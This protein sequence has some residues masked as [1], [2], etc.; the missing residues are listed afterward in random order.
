MELKQ[1][2]NSAPSVQGEYEPVFD[3]AD[4]FFNPANTMSLSRPIIGAIAANKLVNGET[5]VTA[6]VA[7]MALTDAEG[8]VARA[9]DKRSI[10]RTGQTN[11]YG[12][13]KIGKTLDP[14]ADS[15]GFVEVA[16]GAIGSKRIS[17]MG[18]TAVTGLLA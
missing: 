15:L 3:T 18:R 16:V 6:L 7:L 1:A 4:H 17:W 13:T 8:K 10:K 2:S 9:I 11:G 14:I 12:V 5:G